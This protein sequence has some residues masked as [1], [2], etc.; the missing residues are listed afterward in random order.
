MRVT[1]WFAGRRG[2]VRQALP[3]IGSAFL[4]FLLARPAHGQIPFLDKIFTNVT[5]IDGVSAFGQLLN[6]SRLS[7]SHV[8]AIG[9]EV[10]IDVGT[11]GCR[12]ATPAARLIDRCRLKGDTNRMEKWFRTV[13]EVRKVTPSAKLAQTEEALKKINPNDT[14]P[15]AAFCRGL[16]PPTRGDLKGIEEESTSSVGTVITRTYAPPKPPSDG[17][18]PRWNFEVGLGYSVYTG[19]ESDSAN[20]NAHLSG[21]ITELPALSA[22]ASWNATDRLS[23]F[24]GTRIGLN[25]LSGFRALVADTTTARTAVTGS[26]SGYFVGGALGLAVSV[27]DPLTVIGS[28]GVYARRLTGI[29]WKKGGAEFTRPALPQTLDLSNWELN[30][31]LQVTLK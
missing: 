12:N 28:F 1:V 25:Q 3:L 18:E 8:R 17:T 2:R 15:S 19:F 7:K 31:G 9:I 13:C 29:E 14:L 10:F 20:Q 6:D 21:G 16:T 23:L 26:G 30:L 11:A 4:A 24:G 27:A 22:Y 5:S